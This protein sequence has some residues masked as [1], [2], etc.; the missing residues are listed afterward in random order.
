MKIYL[1]WPG[2]IK[3]RWLQDGLEFYLKKLGNYYQV[4]LQQTKAAK[5][6]VKKRQ[7]IVE[8]EG[9]FLKR[10]V[11]QGCYKIALDLH[12]KSLSSEELAFMLK[13][14]EEQGSRR[15]A[16]II[17]GAYGLSQ[18][19]LQDCDFSMSLSRL[20]FTHEMARLILMEQLYRAATINAGSPYHH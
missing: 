9:A 19:V 13:N 10:A 2:K 4:K 8:K 17:G 6:N 7:E 16:F 1:L 12:G 11:P 15:L 14:R 20:T 3:A 5:G 18:A